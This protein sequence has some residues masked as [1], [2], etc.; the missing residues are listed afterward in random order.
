MAITMFFKFMKKSKSQQ[1]LKTNSSSLSLDAFQE[2]KRH[3]LI[4]KAVN[5]S[6]YK[7]KIQL[8]FGG[9]GPTK[10]KI[11]KMAKRLPNYPIF[12][13]FTREQL[14]SLLNFADLYI[15]PADIEVEGMSCIEAI[16][17]GCVP[18]V[19]DS[20]KSATSQFTVDENS[21]FKHGDY[22]DLAKKN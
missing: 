10:K 7:D 6:K 13:F 5:A 17:C 22:K 14:V 1:F 3:D 16:A 8:V 12:S 2:K 18:V 15:H 11:M 4:I 20:P 19:S 21:V 9:K